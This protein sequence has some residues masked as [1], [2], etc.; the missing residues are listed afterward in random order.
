MSILATE[1]QYARLSSL[2][3]IND[4]PEKFEFHTDTLTANE[5]GTPTYN[6]G[7]VLG[8]VTATGKWKIAVQTASD[9]S[10]T[11]A[12]VYIG[13]NFG[14]IVS[15]GPF[16]ASTDTKVLAITRGKIILSAQ[17]LQLDA[18]FSTP[19]LVAGAYASLKTLGILVEQSN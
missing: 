3:K 16:V 2:V 5:S 18:S 13:N 1:S 7:T 12:A 14:Q 10:Q 6:L 17:A 15:T 11:P 8:Q 9:G 4:T 19:T